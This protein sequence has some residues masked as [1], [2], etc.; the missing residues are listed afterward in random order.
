MAD[1]WKVVPR[2]P[3]ASGYR[4]RFAEIISLTDSAFRS[5]TSLASAAYPTPLDQWLTDQNTLY[6]TKSDLFAY[7]PDSTKTTAADMVLVLGVTY[8]AIS[9]GGGG[10]TYCTQPLVQFLGIAK[11]LFTP[12]QYKQ[13]LP[14]WFDQFRNV[15]VDLVNNG[16]INAN[17]I[18]NHNSAGYTARVRAYRSGTMFAYLRKPLDAKVHNDPHIVLDTESP[19]GEQVYWRMTLTGT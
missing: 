3:A 12:A 18:V 5:L 14:A 15:L 10:T 9:G 1:V 2:P 8:T 11:D 17:G 6:P 16:I 13:T 4:T 7:Y 19:W